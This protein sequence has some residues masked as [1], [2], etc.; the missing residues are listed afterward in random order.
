MRDGPHKFLCL[1][2]LVPSLVLLFG[3]VMEPLGT[4]TLLKEMALARWVWALRVSSFTQLP[5]LAIYFL[6]GD[7]L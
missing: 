2:H 6:C 4:V 1:G 3:K 7:E 5:V